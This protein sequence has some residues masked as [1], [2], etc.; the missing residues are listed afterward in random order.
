M[1]L[2][3]AIGI[4]VVAR[5]A[6]REERPGAEC[7]ILRDAVAVAK[8]FRGLDR[9]IRGAYH[10]QRHHQVPPGQDVRIRALSYCVAAHLNPA[11]RLTLQGVDAAYLGPDLKRYC[12][13]AS[14]LD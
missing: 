6:V 7:G 14:T 4:S 9:L 12:V 1:C 10:C 11:M 13:V 8:R 3:R 5:I 2:E